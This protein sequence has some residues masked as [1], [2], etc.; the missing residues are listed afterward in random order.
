MLDWRSRK[1]CPARSEP[2]L[3]TCLLLQ[4]VAED[5]DPAIEALASSAT[6]ENLTYIL[7]SAYL[8]V[9]PVKGLGIL[10]GPATWVKSLLLE[11]G[12]GIMARTA[13]K[14]QCLLSC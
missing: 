10:N 3:N 6:P 1:A 12:Y 11:T 5:H 2:L 4:V 14:V 7:S 9:A 8:V 13:R